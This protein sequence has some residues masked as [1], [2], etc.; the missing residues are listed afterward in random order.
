MQGARPQSVAKPVLPVSTPQKA[1]PP[2]EPPGMFFFRGGGGGGG[3]GGI[4]ARFREGLGAS[5]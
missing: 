2:Q 4:F 1:S 5:L 3:G